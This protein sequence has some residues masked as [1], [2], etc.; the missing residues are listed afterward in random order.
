[1]LDLMRVRVCHTLMGTLFPLQFVAN[2]VEPSVNIHTLG[3]CNVQAAISPPTTTSFPTS[4]LLPLPISL[5]SPPSLFTSTHYISSHISMASAR[6]LL[7][8]P[9]TSDSSH[10]RSSLLTIASSTSFSLYSSYTL[11]PSPTTNIPPTILLSSLAAPLTLP[12]LSYTPPSGTQTRP[13]R[14]ITF[15]FH[16]HYIFKHNVY[17]Y[18]A[19]GMPSASPSKIHNVSVT[20]YSWDS[21]S[22]LLHVDLSW[23]PPAVVNGVLRGYNVS[24]GT[25]PLEDLEEP[26]GDFHITDITPSASPKSSAS[27]S[28]TFN[29]TGT[30]CLY[31]QV[32][33]TLPG[34]YVHKEVHEKP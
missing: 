22:S 31:V 12:S 8:S 19:T 29:F 1:M 20:S 6:P 34:K 7:P 2:F 5:P 33:N 21:A 13:T 32:S 27:L 17:M 9:V 24:I 4:T 3:S 28:A 25:R 10:Q 26:V 18:T 14:K 11:I 16:N 30:Q 23:N 15:E